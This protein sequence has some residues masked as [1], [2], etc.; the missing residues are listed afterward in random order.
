MSVVT[1]RLPEDLHDRLRTLADA[2]GTSL[3]AVIRE[4]LDG[5]LRD[6]EELSLLDRAGDLAGSV[7]GPG[8]LSTNPEHMA[9][10]GR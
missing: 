3:S 8:D 1:V 10:F 6:A 4:I 9:G 2:R 7:E 5:G